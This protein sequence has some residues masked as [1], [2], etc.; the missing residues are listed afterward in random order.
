[1]G[2]D[3]LCCSEDG[4]Y[5]YLYSP[6]KKHRY[7]LEAKLSD[8][9]GVCMFIILNPATEK[10][11]ESRRHHKTR[12][13]CEYFADKEGCGTLWISNVFALRA[14]RPK[15]IRDSSLLYV[16]MNNDDYIRRY[17]HGADRIVCAWGDGTRKA[18]RDRAENVAST[19]IEEG[20]SNKMYRLGERL[21]RNKQP[22]HASLRG[23]SPKDVNL[24][25]YCSLL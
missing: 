5:R 4:K 7:W 22:F 11:D 2:E 1:M 20:F 25:P 3:V 16:G 23:K 12:K 15:F 10:G 21:T 8:K 14:R 9:P 6:D 17:A 19:L 24:V 18:H 13:N